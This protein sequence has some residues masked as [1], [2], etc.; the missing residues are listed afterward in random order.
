VS[1]G[2]GAFARNL[3]RSEAGLGRRA[4]LLVRNLGLR[5]VRRQLCCGHPGEPGC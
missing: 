2:L 5:G 1:R 3:A 4:W